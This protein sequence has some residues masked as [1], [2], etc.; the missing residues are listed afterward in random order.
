RQP[1]QRHRV[2]S[3]QARPA[4]RSHPLARARDAGAALRAA[5][6]P[7]LQPRPGLLGAGPPR[8]G[9]TRVRAGAR[10]RAAV[11]GGACRARGDRS[12]AE[13]AAL[14]GEDRAL[15]RVHLVADAG[16]LTEMTDAPA[17][18]LGEEV[19]PRLR[20]RRHV[21]LAVADR[22]L[23]ELLDEVD[24]VH[25]DGGVVGEERAHLDADVAPD[26]LLVAILN[27]LHA[28][29]GHG[30]RRQI[31]DALHRTELGTLPARPAEVH[32][33][34]RDLARPLLLL[35]ELVGHVGHAFF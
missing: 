14:A 34:E 21:R 7:A 15:L 9:T 33:H 16:A 29:P 8:E 3:H 13:L 2:V 23:E 11:R 24:G 5:P 12:P 30:P 31:L 20:R 19:L 28:A 6:L 26:A 17:A 25:A 27:R 32:V 35:A 22:R 10:D 1:V 18:A 4:R